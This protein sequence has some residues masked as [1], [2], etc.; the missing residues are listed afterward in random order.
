MEK[1][2]IREGSGL[3]PHALALQAAELAYDKKGED[4]TIVDLREFSLGCDY[5]VI[6][7]A[8]SK[9]HLKAIYEEIYGVLRK[10]MRERPWHAEGTGGDRWILLDYVHVVVHIFHQ[11]AREYYKIENLWRDAPVETYPPSVTVAKEP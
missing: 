10:K 9:P 6:I 3:E 8:N 1:D 7:T 11:E 4:I 5:F 2:H